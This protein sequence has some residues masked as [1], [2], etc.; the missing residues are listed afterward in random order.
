MSSGRRWVLTHV[1]LEAAVHGVL[2]QFQL[3]RLSFR[4]WFVITGVLA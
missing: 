2:F 4:A 1:E 3:E